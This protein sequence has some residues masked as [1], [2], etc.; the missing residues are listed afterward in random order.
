MKKARSSKAKTV[1]VTLQLNDY[2]NHLLD[3]YLGDTRFSRSLL[4]NAALN[5][6]VNMTPE[7]KTAAITNFTSVT[8]REPKVEAAV[9]T[10]G[11]FVIETPTGVSKPPKTHKRPYTP[12][13]EDPFTDDINVEDSTLYK[14][15]YRTKE[16]VI[17]HVRTLLS[18]GYDTVIVFKYSSHLPTIDTVMGNLYELS[19]TFKRAKS[20]YKG[21]K[22]PDPRIVRFLQK[23]W[24]FE[25]CAGLGALG[26]ISAFLTLLYIVF[27]DRKRKERRE[28]AYAEEFDYIEFYD[29][30]GRVVRH[31]QKK[32]R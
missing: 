4:I 5:L 3:L 8:G 12:L 17:R 15:V 23:D 18:N 20:E 26:G 31:Y 7:E 21:I 6:F 27:K 14:S 30:N 2:I 1:P 22:I 28:V 19:L 9:A 32:T 16:R 11:Q 25:V 24:F 10:P 29:E 13:P